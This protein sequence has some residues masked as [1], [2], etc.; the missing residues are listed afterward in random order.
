MPRLHA[1]GVTVPGADDHLAGEVVDDE[2]HPFAD[3]D[4]LIGLRRTRFT[5]GRLDGK[6]GGEYRGQGNHRYEPAVSAVARR[7]SA[8][9]RCR[10][11]ARWLVRNAL[12]G[13]ASSARR[14]CSI[15]TS[16]AA[17]FCSSTL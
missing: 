16:M 5:C 8:S 11:E 3:V 6:G 9:L 2:P 10:A 15:A 14:H 17:R 1:D 12:A 13:S 4:G 7:S